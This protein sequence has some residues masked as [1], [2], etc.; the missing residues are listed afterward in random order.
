M[1]KGGGTLSTPERISVSL[2]TE[3]EVRPKPIATPPPSF[4]PP[5]YTP[6]TQA[7]KVFPQ[8]TAGG[9]ESPKII[10]QAPKQ[11]SLV[12]YLLGGIVGAAILF[13]I[14]FFLY[15]LFVSQ[16]KVP[17]IQPPSGEQPL[18]DNVPQNQP[19]G[20]DRLSHRS[21]FK[22]SLQR[23]TWDIDTAT[24]TLMNS[25]AELSR[26]AALGEGFFEVVPQHTDGS[27][28]SWTDYS[29]RINSALALKFF[30][31]NFEKDFTLFIYRDG[32]SLW[33][34]YIL[35]LS[36]GKVPILLQREA[37]KIESSPSIFAG[38]FLTNPGEPGAAFKDGQVGGQPVRIIPFEPSKSVFL[39][40]WFGTE[41]FILGT[42][43]ESVKQAAAR[44]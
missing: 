28:V 35:K 4:T 40:G 7:E 15:P 11:S 6:P 19:G 41:Y 36:G 13:A 8:T 44:L 31:D 42:N 21:F 14:G 2:S 33:P 17:A 29:P 38:F 32:S 9:N 34:G 20:S 12:L 1:G 39:Y 5:A 18:P 22:T 26:G 24:G 25:L 43:E 3:S 23:V 37:A 27:G 30:Q 10:P 16:E